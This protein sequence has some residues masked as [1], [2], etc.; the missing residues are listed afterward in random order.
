LAYLRGDSFTAQ[1]D[2]ERSLHL[3]EGIG[4]SRGIAVCR[5]YLARISP[6]TE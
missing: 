3:F 2:F 6:E 1:R 5:D 4:F